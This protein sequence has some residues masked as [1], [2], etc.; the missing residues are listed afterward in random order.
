MI[1][2]KFDKNGIVH[3]T[4]G[5]VSFGSKELV[6]NYTTLYDTII[7]VRPNG[8]KGTYVKGVSLSTTMGPGVRVST[9]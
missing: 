3:T 6:E 9:K 7:K 5:K 4:I 1:E 2:Y 8:I